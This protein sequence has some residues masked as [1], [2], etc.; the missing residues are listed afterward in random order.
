MMM[1]MSS[2]DRSSIKRRKRAVLPGLSAAP[3]TGEESWGPGCGS[4]DSKQ[5][6]VLLIS[7]TG[8]CLYNHCM[9]NDCR[10]EAGL[11][12]ASFPSVDLWARLSRFVSTRSSLH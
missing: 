2:S 1:M 7:H 4:S 6:A 10:A 12:S 11:S 3:Q 5:E 8:V 9:M